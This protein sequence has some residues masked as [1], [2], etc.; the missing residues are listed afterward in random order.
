LLVSGLW[1]LGDSLGF[2]ALIRDSNTSDYE[3]SAEKRGVGVVE[4]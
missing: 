4:Q 2:W 3:D 1:A